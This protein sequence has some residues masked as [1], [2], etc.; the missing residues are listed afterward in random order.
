MTDT[1]LDEGYRR[2][3]IHLVSLKKTRLDTYIRAAYQ[4]S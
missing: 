2:L 1:S 4:A 3:H